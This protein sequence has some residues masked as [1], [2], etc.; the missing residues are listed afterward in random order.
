MKIADWFAAVG[1]LAGLPD[2][3]KAFVL[4]SGPAAARLQSSVDQPGIVFHWDGKAPSLRDKDKVKVLALADMDDNEA[5]EAMLNYAV[6]LWSGIPGSFLQLSIEA[7]ADASAVANDSQHSI[8]TLP[9][10]VIT[11][12]AYA[13]PQVEDQTIVDCDITIADRSTAAASLL[14]TIIHELGHCIGLGHNHTNY[15]SVMSYGNDNAQL[16]LGADDMAGVIYLY[17]DPDVAAELQGGLGC[18]TIKDFKSGTLVTWLL[19][20]V[21]WI[22]GFLTVRKNMQPVGSSNRQH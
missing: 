4:L 16:K 5:M 1:I 7:D 17:P 22:L 14:A 13:N 10:D 11:L 8:S 18:G 15:H 21:P 3:G 2:S 12:A 19:L 6:G 9:V 20:L